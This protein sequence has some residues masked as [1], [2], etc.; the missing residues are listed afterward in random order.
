MRKVSIIGFAVALLSASLALPAQATGFSVSVD[1]TS[2]LVATADNVSVSLANV[3]SGEGVYVM[4]CATPATGQRPTD[5][6]DTSAW[7]TPDSSMWPYGGVD[8]AA[9]VAMPV[10]ANFGSTNCAVVGC[11]I[12]VRRD[13]LDPTDYSLD[14]FVPVSFA[15]PVTATAVVSPVGNKIKVVV[16]GAKGLTVKVVIAGKTFKVHPKTRV[17]TFGFDRPVKAGKAKV[18]VGTTLIGSHKYRTSH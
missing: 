2:N 15:V 12:F 17:A 4:F 5:C 1:K 18:Y 11:G 6:Q 3:P 9:P 14:T 7:A 8:I 16:T 10:E 13:H